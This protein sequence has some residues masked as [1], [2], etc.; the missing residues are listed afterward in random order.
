MKNFVTLFFICIMM[1]FPADEKKSDLVKKR[2]NPENQKEKK[3]VIN[4][5]AVRDPFISFSASEKEKKLPKGNTIESLTIDEVKLEGIIK[6]KN[7]QFNALLVSP[8]GKSFI[9]SVGQKLYDGE[10]VKITF[11]DVIF[12][13][14]PPPSITKQ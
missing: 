12:R 14:I 1:I 3:T 6:M 9:V 4:P 2:L 10:I 13:K 7:G 11:Q 8:K 5:S